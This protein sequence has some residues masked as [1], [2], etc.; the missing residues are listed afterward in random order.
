V[1]SRKEVTRV[2]FQ[3]EAKESRG[4]TEYR[5]EKKAR[6]LKLL[7]RV[8]H[9]MGGEGQGGVRR[10]VSEIC[11]GGLKKGIPGRI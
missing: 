7:E 1:S 5:K 3:G 9:L 10:E 2:N 4:G 6:V 11:R 8:T